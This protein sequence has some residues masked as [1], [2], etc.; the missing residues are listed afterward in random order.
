M[1]E[2]SFIFYYKVQ[3]V[4]GKCTIDTRDTLGSIIKDEVIIPDDSDFIDVCTIGTQNKQDL[5]FLK[6]SGLSIPILK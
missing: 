4:T 1:Q 3:I 6:T 5:S 2:I